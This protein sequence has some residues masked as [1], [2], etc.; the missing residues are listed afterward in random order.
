MEHLLV[1]DITPH[2]FKLTWTAP[3]SVFDTFTLKVVDSNGLGQPQQISVSGDKRTEAVTG[4][5]EDTEYEIEL[6][7]II[8][9]RKFQPILAVARTG[10]GFL[11]DTG[12]R[13]TNSFLLFQSFNVHS[14][15]R[16]VWSKLH[17][18]WKL[19]TTANLFHFSI[20]DFPIINKISSLIIFFIIVS[21][22][23]LKSLSLT[24]QVHPSLLSFT[25]LT[26]SVSICYVI[27]G[28]IYRARPTILCIY[29]CCMPVSGYF[30]SY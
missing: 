8:L 3:E 14:S 27:E 26:F 1:S 2:S 6:F 23:Y 16:L 4:L 18:K 29:P 7:G 24:T 28:F 19:T 12:G 5:I 15:S 11:R 30:S 9:G 25:S 10:I 21:T 13:T 22:E 17:E 20:T